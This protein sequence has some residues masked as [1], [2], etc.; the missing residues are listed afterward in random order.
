MTGSRSEN[1]PVPKAQHPAYLVS[2]AKRDAG[3]AIT[4]RIMA[5]SV[6][7]IFLDA[8]SRPDFFCP[9]H[10]LLIP[11]IFGCKHALATTY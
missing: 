8:A 5:I 9:G 4:N 6:K 11:K 10:I 7:L 2:V 1:S 3:S